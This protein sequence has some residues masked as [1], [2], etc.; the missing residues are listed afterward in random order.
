MHACTSQRQQCTGGCSLM[1]GRPSMAM[2]HFP[3]LFDIP[4]PYFRKFFGL[5]GTF[6]RFDI[7]PK[8]FRFSSTKISKDLFYKFRIFP[9][10][11]VSI[12][13]PSYSRKLFFPPYFCKIPPLIS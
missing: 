5:R 13:F 12:H 2:L 6:S 3:P 1:Q 7:F 8:K 10:F 11:P 9:Y 4:P